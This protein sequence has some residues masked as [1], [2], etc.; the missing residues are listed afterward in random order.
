MEMKN[1]TTDALLERRSAIAAELDAEGADL[2]ALEAE[3]RSINTELEARKAAESKRAEIRGMV[4][5]GAGKKIAGTEVRTAA[6]KSD[7]EVRASKAYID[8]YAAYIK[9]GDAT[10]CRALLTEGATGG[11]VPVPTILEGR[12]RTAWEKT[13]LLSKVKR[14]FAKGVLRVGFE[15]SATGA[16]VHTEGGDAPDEET[17]TIGVVELTPASIKKWITIS[18]EALDMT[19]EDFLQ[20][21]FDEITYQILRKAQQELIAA[22]T[23]APA[24][25]T[26]T[27]VG[28]P[29]ISGQPSL[30][31]VAE[32]IGNLSDEASKPVVI[33]NKGTW[34]AFKAVQYAGSFSVDP[35][36]GLDVIFDNSLKTYAAASSG[37]VWMI[38]G[39]PTGAQANFPNGDG[40]K[41]K[42]DDLSLAEADLVKI[43]GRL[44]VALGL[45]ADDSFVTV[46]KA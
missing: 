1:M 13:D 41:L 4:G 34:A 35:F 12:I 19:G 44:Y 23:A 9:T 22:I 39:D 27:A 36:E 46:T 16:A 10:E 29:T 11:T 3:V 7:A 37:E 30:G 38:V 2:D 31:I 21:V 15:M 8:A 32:A 26:A 14:T 28:V 33:I 40:V 45:T 5:S 20:Y 25:A 17:L 6:P 24:T 42:Y 18:D 43:V